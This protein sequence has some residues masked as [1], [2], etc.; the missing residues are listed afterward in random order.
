MTWETLEQFTLTS[1]WQFTYEVNF[2][3]LRIVTNEINLPNPLNNS[4]ARLQIA[5]VQEEI[6]NLV[7]Y[8]VKTVGYKE[9][10]TAFDMLLPSV[11]YDRKLAIR[12]VDSLGGDWNVTLQYE[13]GY[14][15]T[16]EHGMLIT[17]SINPPINPLVGDIWQQEHATNGTT[18]HDWEFNGTVWISKNSASLALSSNQS[19]NLVTSAFMTRTMIQASKVYLESFSV[20]L[21]SNGTTN[22]TNYADLGIR[23]FTS[24]NTNANL[25]NF[26]RIDTYIANNTWFNLPIDRTIDLAVTPS[27][28][29]TKT[30][31]NNPGNV[32]INGRI[33]YKHIYTG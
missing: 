14:V 11:F 30:N 19:N 15:S 29:L 23:T 26:Y 1:S 8:D 33:N 21:Q 6:D 5:Q 32:S 25:Y 31:F 18:V 2:T 10:Y 24:S 20:L 7:L 13:S 17:K 9:E 4:K 27:F 3:F 28:S 12:R 22:D 16:I